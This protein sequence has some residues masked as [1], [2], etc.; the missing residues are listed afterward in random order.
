[1][2]TNSLPRATSAA[3]ILN[4]GRCPVPGACTPRGKRPI[5]SSI[6]DRLRVYTCSTLQLC[7]SSSASRVG[8]TGSLKPGGGAG[9]GRRLSALRL[10]AL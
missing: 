7:V 5:Y 9:R 2:L 4:P 1:M 8:Q 6:S 3:Q 10:S